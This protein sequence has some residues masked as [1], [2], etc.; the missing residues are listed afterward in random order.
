MNRYRL[1]I[2]ETHPIQYKAPLFR[3]LAARED[4]A[5]QVYYAMIPDAAQQGGG[6]DVPF[7]WD[8]PLLDGYEY[9]VLK[10]RARR[11]SVS[12][13]LGCDTP[14]IYSHLQRN[15]PDAVLVNGWVAKTCLQ[16]LWAC[17]RLH[18]PCLVRGEANLLRPRPWWKH[19]L[20]RRLMRH[21]DGWL[22]IGSANRDFYRFHQCPEERIFWAPYAVDNHFFEVQA[23]TFQGRQKEWRAHVGVPAEPVLLLFV[24]K[25]IGKKRPQDILAAVAQLPAEWKAKVHVLFAG[26]GPLRAECERQARARH[27]PVTFAGFLNQS[28]LP[29]AY[30]AADVL[31]LPSDAGETWGL[32]VNEAM[33]SG[34]P[35]VVSRSV[36]CCADLMVENRTGH[37]FECGDIAA[38]AHILAGYA[39]APESARQQGLAAMEHIRGFRLDV[40][41]TG[42]MEALRASAHRES[43]W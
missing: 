4:L 32:V 40:T 29:R 38:L 11:P 21:Y 39:R 42:I 30:A 18:I 26:D 14:D 19:R 8:V 10:N 22:A 34:R 31:V 37:S 23:A 15:R 13:F 5:L 35:A 16:A 43:A 17:K 27:L 9:Q 6:F 41:V 25:L 36:G 7:M 24:G 28:Q 20:H 1:A 2:V 12:S 3:R 33:A